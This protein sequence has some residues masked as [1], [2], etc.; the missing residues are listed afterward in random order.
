M[1]FNSLNHLYKKYD[2][3][4]KRAPSLK[5]ELQLGVEK[6]NLWLVSISPRYRASINLLDFA[7]SQQVR[8]DVALRIFNDATELSMFS[9]KYKYRNE[10]TGTIVA[11]SKNKD[12]LLD[13]GRSGELFNDLTGEVI[14]FVPDL[15]EKYFRLVEEP[16]GDYE[17]HVSNTFVKGNG[18]QPLTPKLVKD[19]TQN[20]DIY[21]DDEEF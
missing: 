8:F 11:S 4:F 10:V 2:K 15:I 3:Q 1:Y 9:T 14:P 13:A 5:M 7:N 20:S 21:D 17:E 12:D 16:N 18:E 19:K 6:L